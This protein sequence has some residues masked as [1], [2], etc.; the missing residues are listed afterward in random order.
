MILYVYGSQVGQ[1]IPQGRNYA[2][3]ES[4]LNLLILDVL[5][6]TLQSLNLHV[7]IVANRSVSQNKT[8]KKKKKKKKKNNKKNSMANSEDTDETARNEPSHLDLHRLL[9]N[10][11]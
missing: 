10:I 11:T 9:Q 2:R 5:N 4:F 1:S 3:F 7:S 6:R 8:K